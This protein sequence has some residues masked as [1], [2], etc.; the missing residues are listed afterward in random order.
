MYHVILLKQRDTILGEEDDR[1]EWKIHRFVPLNALTVDDE[2]VVLTP[3][4]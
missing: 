2:S 3:T 1:D 4:L